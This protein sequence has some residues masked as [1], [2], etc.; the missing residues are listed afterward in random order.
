MDYIELGMRSMEANAFRNAEAQAAQ[1][2]VP[3]LLSGES[4][5][6]ALA[7]AVKQLTSVAPEDYDVL[8]QVGDV[9]VLEARFIEPHTFAFKGLN[10]E[11]HQ[12]WAV[13]HFSQLNARIVYHPK[14]GPNRRITGFCP[15]PST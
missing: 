9:S 11:G 5:W 4:T 6:L 14:R 3:S 10:Q 12:T 1:I 13:I 15:D 2:V 8:I 7:C